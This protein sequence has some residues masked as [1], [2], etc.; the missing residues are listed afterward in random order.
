[1]ETDGY[2]VGLAQILVAGGQPEAN[3]ARA[4]LAIRKAADDGCRLVVLPECLD[5]GWTDPSARALAQAIPGPHAA[6]LAAAAREHGVYVAAG[7]VERHSERHVERQAERLFNAAVLLSPAGEILLHYRKLNELDI[8]RD[9][10]SV[11]DRLGVA[12]TELGVLGLNICA[13][14]FES[15]L[16]IG[17]TL[18][19]MG[20]QVIL[21]PSAWAVEANHDQVRDPYGQ[22]WTSAYARLTSLYDL[23]VIGV[24]NVGWI[25]GGPWQG[26][27]CIGCSLAMGPGGQVLAQGPYGENAATVVRV[28]IHP[29]PPIARGTDIA[30]ALEQRGYRG[31]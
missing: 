22:L 12:H 18:A 26:R 25:T 30:E 20:A 24:S 2:F 4:A 29:R 21:S 8:A 14:N 6:A 10:Y 31:P 9:L 15:S 11:G 16:A 3:L 23:T 7:L 28:K 5:L 13:D 19:R 27:K 1:M 17:H